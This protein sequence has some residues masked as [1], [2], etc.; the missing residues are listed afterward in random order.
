[1]SFFKALYDSYQYALD[2]DLV[3]DSTQLNPQDKDGNV[4][5]HQ[6][7]ILP[8][9]HN[10]LRSTGKN[11]VELSLDR[12]S[13]LIRAEYLPK[14]TMIVFPVTED[15]LARTDTNTPHPLCDFFNYI[16]SDSSVSSLT[17]RQQLEHWL[18]YEEIDFVRYFYNFITKPTCCSE[19]LKKLFG[20]YTILENMKIS[21][22]DTLGKKPKNVS[23]NLSDVFITYRIE[24]YDGL[25]DISVSENS[26][27]Q[28]RYIQYAKACFAQ[29]GKANKIQCNISGKDDYLCLKHRGIKGNDK[30]ISQ[31]TC[32]K[33]NYF[34]RFSRPEDTVS[35]G[36]VT[37]Q[38]I[39]QMA[40]SLLDGSNT[41]QN[42]G[43]DIY[44]ISWFSDDIQN[45]S[46]M[47]LSKGISIPISNDANDA[48]TYD[49]FN[50]AH[51]NL[52]FANTQ[53]PLL[54]DQISNQ[55]LKSFTSGT[56]R[57]ADTA[58]YYVAILGK[59]NQ[60]SSRIFLNYFSAV[61]V[62]QLRARLLQWS[63][64][65]SWPVK[66]KDK[67][68]EYYTPSIPQLINAAYGIEVADTKKKGYNRLE[69]SSKKHYSKQYTNLVTAILGGR[70]MPQ[71]ITQALSTNIRLRLKY[72]NTWNWIVE[73]ALAVLKDQEGV[74]S[75]MLDRTNYD[76]SYLYGRLLGLYEVLERATFDQD[77]TRLTNAENLWTTFVNRPEST[78]MRLR[79]LL[80][81]Y[82][83]KLMADN[84]KRGILI[85]IKKEISEVTNLIG[86][87][88]PMEGPSAN[89]PLGPSFIFGYEAQKKEHF[90]KKSTTESDED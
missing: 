18:A 40:K 52:L 51:S 50:L 60:N 64:R 34:G 58:Q 66:R 21:Y 47:D 17:Y 83:K 78:N 6:N 20:D 54:G 31:I 74:K 14:S 41:S 85:K 75:D 1:M 26:D 12:N 42:L 43:S 53:A 59:A 24:D 35:I 38:E 77:T 72:T 3:A 46:G 71:N 2:H 36:K 30:M 27:L 44:A 33:E 62:P 55:I 63:Q 86:D 61:G 29:D 5:E 8:I 84:N 65:Y 10:S 73:C 19:I 81:P 28:Q 56:I 68:K 89:K 57:F 11:I 49:I 25:R 9:F 16:I 69:V 23:V 67:P 80:L 15:S 90:T 82:E 70:Q 88:Y 45:D 22:V 4:L 7:Y 79:L 13:N 76:R 48:D 37:S 32:S 87:H 39:F